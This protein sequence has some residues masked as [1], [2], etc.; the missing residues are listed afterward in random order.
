MKT[1]TRFY[2]LTAWLLTS[3]M[4]MTFIPSFT[5]SVSAQ[6]IFK[7][8]GGQ[9]ASS[10]CTGTYING[11][12]SKVST[13][14]EQ[15]EIS[16]TT[17]TVSNGGQLYW[18]G[19][20][21]NITRNK[22]IELAEDIVVNEKV[23][24][25]NGNLISDTSGLREWNPI[26]I[27]RPQSQPPFVGKFIGNGHTISGLYY[28]NSQGTAVGLFGQ[29]NSGA[30]VTNV[31]VRDSYFCGHT[32]VGGIA[33]EAIGTAS[34]GSQI[35][36]CSFD[37]VV[38][39]YNAAGGI[40]ATLGPSSKISRCYTDGKVEATLK[41][42]GGIVGALLNKTAT[43]DNCYNL[44]AVSCTVA[45]STTGVGIGT[46]G[47]ITG[48]ALG[49]IS[50]CHNYGTVTSDVYAGG[51][52]GE[53]VVSAISSTLF[54]N[55]Y[56]L[57]TSSANGYGNVTN[58]NVKN[59]I[60]SRGLIIPA[61]AEQFASGEIC[62]ILNDRSAD[63]NLI[64]RQNI[65]SA[66]NPNVDPADAYPKF[67]GNV[68]DYRSAYGGY[69][70]PPHTHSWTYTASGS[71]IT[72]TCTADGCPD[73]NGGSVTIAAP[74]NLTYSGEAIE[75]K[76]TNTLTTGDTVTVVY[77]PT[78][79]L[80]DGKPVN[81][82]EYTAS[83]TLDTD[84]K[85]EATYTIIPKPLTVKGATATNREYNGTNIVSVT[86]VELDG[87]CGSDT[88]A[89]DTTD[90]IGTISGTDAGAYDKVTLPT[91]SLTNNETANYTFTQPT[92][93]V[94]TSVT[95]SKLSYENLLALNLL[96]IE[97]F[98]NDEKQTTA[99]S[100]LEIGDKIGIKLTFDTSKGYALPDCV[101]TLWK[102][103]T[104]DTDFVK[105]DDY[106]FDTLTGVVTAE[107][108]IDYTPGE[109][110]IKLT[111][112]GATNYAD[113]STEEETLTVN[114]K[115]VTFNVSDTEH[116]YET[117][118]KRE[119][120]FTPS[121]LTKADYEVK[122][123]LVNEN[124][125]V[126]YSTTPETEAITAGKYLYVIDFAAAQTGYGITDK[127]EVTSTALPTGT[128][129][130]CGYMYIKA[131]SS[132]SAQ[133]PIY[134]KDGTVNLKVNDTHTNE[135][136]NE[137]G[138]TPTF[139]SSNTA[140]ATVDAS[141]KV[142]AVGK[143]TATITAK[144]EKNGTTPVYASYTVNVGL[145]TK[146]LTANDF[147]VK[148]K[149]KTYN[150]TKDVIISAVVKSEALYTGDNIKVDITGEFADSTAG[151]SKTVNYK[152]TGISGTGAE[153]YV[154]ENSEISGTTTAKIEKA[155]IT[156]I[157]ATTTTRIFD[158]T[159]QGVDV[160][161]MA[162]GAVFDSSNYAV[163]YNGSDAPSAVGLY[164]V[165]VELTEEAEKNYTVTQ[166]SAT[167]IIKE[168]T[169]EVFSVEG[170]PEAVYYGDSF[171]LSADGANG[172]V[173]YTITS[174]AEVATING[175]DV[176]VTGVGKVTIQAKSELAGHNDRYATKTFEVKKRILTP[177]ATATD[178]IYDGTNSVDVSISLETLVSGDV[179]TA[180]ATGTML[181]ADAGE[182]KIVYVSGVTL[183]GAKKD[184]YTL[185][186]TSIQ[187]TVNIAKKEITGITVSASD[188]K[189]DGNEKAAA[190]VETITGVIPADAGLVEVIG[191]AVFADAN[192]EENKTV[193]FTASSLVGAKAA[194]YYIDGMLIADTTATISPV[195]VNFVVGQT[196]F[197]YDG[198]DK[199]ITLSASDEFGRIFT[200]FDVDYDITPN[201]AGTYTATVVL[202]DSV[203][204]ETTQ[205]EIPVTISEATQENLVIVGL[206]G[207][208]QYGDSFD[209]EAIGGEDGGT[210]EWTVKNGADVT[211]SATDKATTN[212]TIGNVVDNKV[213]IE[214]VKK[215]D[216]FEDISA[217]VVF[218]P[219]SK[220]V[221]FD[222]SNLEQTYDGSGKEIDV[223]TETGVTY[224]VKY[225]NS[226]ELPTEAGTYTVKVEANGNYSG[227]QTATL[228][229]KKATAT[230]T[231]TGIDDSYTYGE[232]IT[233]VDVTDL[234]DSTSAKITYAGTGIYVPQDTPPAK[235]GNYTVIAEI[236]GD[237]YE[238]LTV[239]KNF[240]I[241]KAELTVKAKNTTKTYGE[242]NP[243]FELEYTGFV[244]GETKGVLLAEP[245]ATVN[246]NASSGVGEYDITISGG[247][248]EN[249]KFSY[250]NTGK[251]T[252]TSATGSLYITGST[253]TV[254][255]ND[256]FGL[257][258][259][260][261]NSKV[262]VT[263]ESSDSTIA[264]IA[265][266]GTVTAK[267]AGTVTITATPDANYGNAEATFEL[268]VKQ[269]G[270]I[271]VPTGLVKTYTG[272]RQ[273][274]TFADNTDFT[275]VLSGE[276]KN[277]D[278]TYTLI[279][280][281]SVTE[282]IQAGTYSVV[283][284]ISDGRYTGGGNT[285][286]YINK[287]EIEVKP[288]NIT[289]IYGDEPVYELETTSTLISADE[290]TALAGNTTF[291]SE[292]ASKAADVK[293]GGYEITATLNTTENENIKFVVNGT[294]TLTV[295][296]AP[297][298]VKV[299]DVSREYGAEN[300]TLEAE[301]T[302][303][304]N[305]ESENTENIFTGTLALAYDESITAD[306][307]VGEY[308]DKTTASG[309]D[310]VNYAITFEQGKVTITKIGVT[311]SAGTSRSSYLTV[312][313]D[314]AIPGL[315]KDNFTVTDG[316]NP[317]EITE[318]TAS[319]DNKTYTLKG[320]F[321]TSVTYM[322]TPDLT[323]ST[324]EAT[325]EI[326]NAPLSIKPASSGGGGGGGG[327][328][329]STTY[330]V[331]FET[332]EGS[333]ID[334]VK[335]TRNK[336]AQE[337]TAPTKEGYTFNGWYTDKE[338]T[339]VYDF[340]TKVT[341]SFT[342]YAK[343]EKHDDETDEPSTSDKDCNGTV[344]DECPSLDFGDLDVKAWYHP[345]TDYVIEN[346]I[347]EGVSEIEF[348]PDANLTRA[349]LV[350]VLY[351]VEGEIATNES[352]PFADVDMGAYY[353]NAV[354]WAKQNGIVK[355]VSETEFAPN[356]NITREQIAAV[357]HRYAEYKG[358]DVS[359]GE[360][361]NI[362]SYDDFDSISEYAIVSMQW[363]VGSG[364]IKGKSESTLSPVDNA[365]RAEV[366][367]ILHRFIEANK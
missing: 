323:G 212:V 193:T 308:A 11:F 117:G 153:N 353:G 127:F 54:V 336:T 226:V 305:E 190:T 108:V 158:G 287:A 135:L 281:P 79:K 107:K 60:T 51:I 49:N 264:E 130:N 337:P 223:N 222:I 265:A 102:K 364:L 100:S 321:S 68:V 168:A 231:I 71:T 164:A 347:F 210:Y 189:Y 296:K 191:S 45:P 200:D 30:Q 214:V 149:D 235:V 307:A 142:T 7:A 227:M 320:S 125:G 169:Q 118:T 303:F 152:I 14:Y 271:L 43:V 154:L 280:N 82:G 86:A 166:P 151:D 312:K 113:I 365:T 294:G 283:Y 352:S 240:V 24:D 103:G 128:Y 356:D 310:S 358:Y 277:I 74:D 177:T 80:T 66:Y 359:I 194:N 145:A 147:V 65:K 21:I 228:T 61:T 236:T 16:G 269:T 92:D 215:T 246:A 112:N 176:T 201:A 4:L 34:K 256:V 229:I 218:V 22:T 5:L 161:A 342:L 62:H 232:T 204:Y 179:I 329:A 114:K 17:Y 143:G 266:N 354:S 220:V 291:T 239:T 349:M 244:N 344:T 72:A 141:G 101:G 313:F 243:I 273:D 341:K 83:I 69:Y 27:R 300:P 115:S 175:T 8:T 295:A 23:L 183:D 37:G 197:V 70:N 67:K 121:A 57:N 111:M 208:I 119:I 140:V 230:G 316:T 213:E 40:T 282:P 257:H 36:D 97:Y 216:N 165:T 251:L 29:I 324:S 38:I 178:R 99:P 314:K 32:C 185:D 85:I 20:N 331:K 252:V 346:G 361:T 289:K 311:L 33:G 94:D 15:P 259:F 248:A 157:C 1:K 205:G 206:P 116:T 53:I 219:T 106:A 90:L 12:C 278:V 284:T 181:N 6:E 104:E 26:G 76:V 173:T 133:K 233:G 195:T 110:V 207:T 334:S 9:C 88:V 340:E 187:T 290:L 78:E 91:L 247:S 332:N 105:V 315:T 276:G 44:A 19:K 263:W 319:N 89:V 293:N 63:G 10:E 325:H 199:K 50:Y 366:A 362:L 137:N 131:A 270:I 109:Y 255:V 160:S 172:N 302:G 318:A 96:K 28:S 343:W 39:G 124:S 211:L 322:V 46:A 309:I 306:L 139:T 298:T 59:Y 31:H 146:M 328:S 73:T 202:D 304:K 132:S 224:D 292:G 242:A 134:F 56:Y 237:N 268:T 41:Q 245:I 221:T 48:S 274:I 174:G 238:T 136:T 98:V 13:H 301:Y 155:Q 159:P 335:V 148:A 184:L 272:E 267:K 333:K 279:S 249:Y 3:A 367:A 84:K 87:I 170:V 52:A 47:G 348:A 261:G 2:K 162:N 250:N 35:T 345:D 357:M 288:K 126:L 18:V 120:T 188:K 77:T 25:S 203:N 241:E 350:T 156:I 299:K 182:N 150:G 260:Y 75:A 297:L 138:T 317:V 262:N 209:L 196:S 327:S 338:L 285:T 275:P 351:R 123:Y 217:K 254:Y 42:A 363:A 225:N 171:T 186:T 253:N 234:K 93:A 198:N 167:L 326:V 258:A 163:K 129:T 355:G 64:W 55:C 144:S 81:V 339:K 95:I 180:T 330:T 192:S 122:Y 360:N 286:M 58:A